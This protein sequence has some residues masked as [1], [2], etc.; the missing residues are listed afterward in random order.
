M[1]WELKQLMRRYRLVL[2]CALGVTFMGAALYSH[3]GLGR[4]PLGNLAPAPWKRPEAHVALKIEGMDCVMCAAGLQNNLRAIPGVRRA[5]VSFQD[6]QAVLD[7]DP[8][9]VD[10]SGFEKVIADSGFKVA[11]AVPQRH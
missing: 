8:A 4:P 5:D 9:A 1:S 7:Y 11:L 6:K 2:L 10:E 3:R